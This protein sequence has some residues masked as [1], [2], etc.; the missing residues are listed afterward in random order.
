MSAGSSARQ[1]VL[2]SKQSPVDCVAWLPHQIA[3]LSHVEPRPSLLRLGNRQG[4]TTAGAA[5]LIWRARGRHPF[6]PVP[7]AP[8]RLAMINMKKAQSVEIQR[9]LFDLLGGRNSQ[10]LVRCDFSARTG[11]RGHKPMVEFKNGSS[12]SIFTSGQGA[13]ALAGSEFDHILGDEPLPEDVFDEMEK[14]VLNTGGTI[15]LTLTPINGPPLPWLRAKCEQGLIR[16]YHFR[17]E[18][19]LQISPLTGRPRRTKD[20][21]PWDEAFIAEERRKTNPIIAPIRLDGEWESRVEGQFFRCFDRNRHVSDRLPTAE[22]TWYL[23]LDYAAADRERGLCAVLVGHDPAL[24]VW[25][26]LGEHV[27]VG[28]TSM[29]DFARGIL[30]MLGDLGLTWRD[31]DYVYGD[32]AA[33]SRYATSS[34]V[35][36][37]KA[38]A[39]ALKT[40]S[41][42]LLP[43]IQNAKEGTASSGARR[44]TKDVRSRWLY[45]V[46]AADRVRIHPRCVEVIEALGLWDYS[47]NHER[48]DV[49]DALMYGPVP[50]WSSKKFTDDAVLQFG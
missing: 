19:R 6:K 29:T 12:I 46:M 47:D 20:G 11:F 32:I 3:W 16:D 31:L 26:V 22:L 28:S 42:G 17:L 14:R 50:V 48:K 37:A 24:D 18:A 40:T 30:R 41:A 38:L 45:G 4:K 1:L 36:L 39:L 25:H 27:V 23:G 44:R 13:D 33:R 34:N 10:D 9:V 2:A 49:L 21:R 43:R 15:G 7:R 5:D 8:V 35:E